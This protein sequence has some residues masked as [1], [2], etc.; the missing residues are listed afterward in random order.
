MLRYM[1]M[2]CAALLPAFPASAQ[3]PAKVAPQAI[4]LPP[5]NPLWQPHKTKNY[6]PEMTWAEVADLLKRTDMVIIPVGS[7]EQHGP[8]G[9]LGTDY[10]NGLERAKLVAQYTDVLVAPITNVGNAGYH[11]DFPGSL[12]VSEETLQHFYVEVVQSLIKQGFKRFMFLNSHGGNAATTAFI[13]DRINQETPGIAVDLATAAAPF[14]A[15]EPKTP[16][17]TAPFDRHAGV[18]ETSNSLYLI[19]SLVDLDRA[20]KAKLTMPDHLTK[21]VPMIE[22]GDPTANLVF[23]VEALKAEG[24]GKGTT[25]KN[26]TDTGSWSSLDPRTATA[27]QGHD[28]TEKFVNAAVQF[29]EKWKELRPLGTK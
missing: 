18:G 26:M 13:V 14:M 21:M 17:K 29:I 20:R 9:P 11:L 5:T 24:T 22:A 10:L 12:S 3:K 27:E 16:G 28:E 19:P 7:T 15:R 23:L 25:T 2:G 4:K 8:Q 6:L 1:L